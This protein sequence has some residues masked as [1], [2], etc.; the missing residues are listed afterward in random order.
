[1]VSRLTRASSAASD[2]VNH[3]S[4]I[5]GIHYDRLWSK[6][7]HGRRM[8]APRNEVTPAALPGKLHGEGNP[9][10]RCER[11]RH[12]LVTPARTTAPEAGHGLLPG[13][14][15]GR[16]VSLGATGRPLRHPRP[17]LPG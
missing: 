2:T 10:V 5:L 8:E 17:A 12:V 14:A 16:R 1:M 6:M 11:Y 9:E 15:Q 3:S 4:V 13:G 7:V